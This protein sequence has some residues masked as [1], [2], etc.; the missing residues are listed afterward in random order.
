M[1][2]AAASEGI[3]GVTRIPFDSEIAH[4]KATLGIP[5]GYEIACYLALG[6]PANEQPAIRQ[7]PVDIKAKI[8]EDRW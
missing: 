1:L 8:H 4:L 5:E 2:L 7:T 6:Y 3:L